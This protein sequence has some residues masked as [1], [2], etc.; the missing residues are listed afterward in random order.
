MMGIIIMMVVAITNP[1]SPPE[2]TATTRTK[3]NRPFTTLIKGE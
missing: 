3:I 1:T 2:A